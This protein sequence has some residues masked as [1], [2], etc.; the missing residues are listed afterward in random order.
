MFPTELTLFNQWV[1]WRLES[2]NGKPT[3][4]PYNPKTG[5][6]ADHSDPAT[7]TDYC[8][9]VSVASNGGN[10]S[11]I[12][13]VL[14]E[15]DPYFIIDL[16]DPEGNP[17][18]I[19]KQL[20]VAQ[21]FDT[22]SEISPSGKGLH[23]IGRG[24]VHGGRK[25]HKIEIY[26]SLRYF[27]MTGNTYQ[28]R[29]I[30]DRNQL[31]NQLWEELGDNGGGNNIELKVISYP[32]KYSDEL[33][34]NCAIQANNATKFLDLWNGD[35]IKHYKSQSEADF[36]LI[37]ILGF[38][39]RNITQ[40]RR[41][42]LQSD[43]GKRDKA[44]KRKAYVD[45]M[46]KRSFDNLPPLLDLDTMILAS[47]EEL[48]KKRSKDTAE[49][50]LN[51]NPWSGSL[52]ESLPDPNYDW[53]KPPGLVGEISN[54][55]YNASPRPIKEVAL[56]A[57]IGLM[58]GI[59]GRSYNVSNTGLNTYVLL[60]AKT[61][62]GK[63]AAMTGIEK[64]VEAIRPNVPGIN[65]FIGP[66]DIASGQALIKYISKHPCFVSMVGEFGLMLEQ[67][68]SQH[69][70]PVQNNLKR[71]LLELYGKSGN[72]HKLRPTIYSDNTKDTATVDSPAFSLYG[73]STPEVFYRNMNDA[74]IT[75]GLLPRFMCVEYFGDRPDPNDDA[76]KAVPARETVDALS[77]LSAS[78]LHCLQTNKI[79]DVKYTLEAEVLHK[80]IRAQYDTYIRTSEQVVARELWSR[81][82]L[83]ILKLSALIAIGE[84]MYTPTISC[85]SLD[86]A[87]KLVERDVLNILSRFESGKAGKE[88]GE[89]NQ[90]NE[91]VNAIGYFVSKQHMNFKTYNLSPEMHRDGI[92]PGSYLNRRLINMKA[93]KDDRSGATIAINRAIRSL[94]DEGSI[95]IVPR[96]DMAKKYNSSAVA[97]YVVDVN[98]F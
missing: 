61:G 30:A 71:K 66:A 58:A 46:I 9:A 2:A 75:E 67:M 14:S 3:K 83:K 33:I 86:W 77:Y 60:I 27:T 15:N 16:D 13:F 28:D 20:K 10:Y 73:E 63:E 37:N 43:L 88:A 31:A 25:R 47:A 87:R 92:I 76:Y 22:Y 53:T 45:T 26:S 74:I 29:P 7:W 80:K 12:G 19:E 32:E 64:L 62:I 89:L 81:A 8:T 48:M 56:A 6:R 44:I 59:C 5:A 24:A 49:V 36:A 72:K 1:C 35:W 40:I 34:Y 82:H 84:N 21:Q 65:E 78:A 17:A 95:R 52:F 79:I 55:I 11:G 68:H 91:L 98:R 96:P 57:A 50:D 39:S 51:V 4:V 41:M 85:E 97:Y 69:A 70:N 94:I 23:I 42:F 54:F 18:I 93:F 38:Y 90:I